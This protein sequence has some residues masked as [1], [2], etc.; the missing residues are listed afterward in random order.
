ML[1]RRQQA[2]LQA[3]DITVWN[4]RAAAPSS[5]TATSEDAVELRL[6]LGPGNGGVLLVCSADHESAGRLA[7]DIARTLGGAPVWAWPVAD[8]TA[9]TLD[10]AVEENLFSTV[11]FFGS[12]LTRRFFSAEPPSHIRSARL[13]M[14]PAMQDIRESADA[15]RTLWAGI[16]QSGMLDQG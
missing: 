2:Y 4:L 11:A 3:M 6:K 16:C 13:V 14:L 15:R 9:A 7:S 8:E 5:S 1:S 10:D 12:E